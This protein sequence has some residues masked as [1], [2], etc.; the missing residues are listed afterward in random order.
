VPIP[1]ETADA[2]RIVRSAFA[3]RIFATYRSSGRRRGAISLATTGIAFAHLLLDRYDCKSDEELVG[4]FY[5]GGTDCLGTEKK[6]DEDAFLF[7]HSRHRRRQ[8]GMAR[9]LLN[10]EKEEAEGVF[11][12]VW[13]KFDLTRSGNSRFDLGRAFKPWIDQILRREVANQFRK[14]KELQI[15]LN[16]ELESIAEEPISMDLGIDTKMAFRACMSSLT[17]IEQ[18]TVEYKDIQ[19]FTFEETA[20][21]LVIPAGTVPGIRERAHRKLKQCMNEKGYPAN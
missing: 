12:V 13:T 2:E 8:V 5:I 3:P 18:Q 9:I 19:G 10:T 16:S 17:K 15:D 20:Q 14:R 6:F 21:R 11:D 4:L 1:I 7:L